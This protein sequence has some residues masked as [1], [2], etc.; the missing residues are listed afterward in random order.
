[1]G[2]KLF[3]TESIGAV[4]V[5][6]RKGIRKI[7]LT[8]KSNED[9]RV[10]IPKYLSYKYGLEF[11]K[12][13]KEW[14]LKNREKLKQNKNFYNEN[15]KI[16]LI[17]KPIVFEKVNIPILKVLTSGKKILISLPLNFNFNTS[18]HQDIIKDVLTETIRREAKRYLPERLDEL[19]KK[20]N[21]PYNKVF[22]KNAK[23]LW[24]SCSSRN[25]INLN[26]HLMRLPGYLIDYVLLHELS[27]VVHKNH[28]NHFWNFLN[29]IKPNS[30]NLSKELKQHTICL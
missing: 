13:N 7:K 22:I 21:I 4:S 19:A 20:Y 30:K 10:T 15:S 8:L 28:S 11:A 27:H 29:E 18:E 12:S 6:K 2:K 26:L 25:N 17:T 3:L 16:N 1:M 5:F 24:G 23:T 9:V 14:I